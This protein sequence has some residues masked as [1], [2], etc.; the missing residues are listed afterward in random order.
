MVPLQSNKFLRLR[1]FLSLAIL[2]VLL[3]FVNLRTSLEPNMVIVNVQPTKTYLSPEIFINSGNGF[4]RTSYSSGQILPFTSNDFISFRIEF[5]LKPYFTEDDFNFLEQSIEGDVQTS[6]WV[7]FLNPFKVN[8]ENYQSISFTPLDQEGIYE[9]F[10]DDASYS[11]EEVDG[12][13][14]TEN[15]DLQHGQAGRI[16]IARTSLNPA[17]ES[18]NQRIPL[19]IGSVYVL[20][21]TLEPPRISSIEM[22]KRFSRLGL[23]IPMKVWDKEGINECFSNDMQGRDNDADPN[24][25]S[26]KGSFEDTQQEII[27]K[28]NLYM[29]IINLLVVLSVV[30][31]F[32]LLGRLISYFQNRKPE[33]GNEITQFFGNLKGGEKSILQKL[34]IQGLTIKKIVSILLKICFYT[35][36][37]LSFFIA[38]ENRN[39]LIFLFS[40]GCFSIL[41]ENRLSRVRLET[42]KTDNIKRKKRIE[43]LVVLIIV[44]VNG[45]ALFYR[46]GSEGFKEDEFQVIDSAAGYLY[47]GQ[48]SRWD[49][50]EEDI[51]SSYA[52]AWPHTFL[53]AQAFKLLGIS[54]FSGRVVSVLGGVVFIICF[55]FFARFFT[56][57]KIALLTL[58]STSLFP[59]Y[60]GLFRYARMYALLLPMF[61]ILTY[62]I[63]RG[64]TGDWHVKTG[65]KRLDAF[66][67]KKINYDYRF[68]LASI[69]ILY[70][71]Y[72]IHVNS[73]II[74]L[75]AYL[76]VC[77]LAI[78]DKEKKF[79]I[80]AVLGLIV[81]T[82]LISAMI[83][84]ENTEIIR[85]S[86]ESLPKF[87][88]FFSF[89]GRKN[90]V[91]LDYLV[92][93]P[94]G[95][96]GGLILVGLVG[97]IIFKKKKT[98]IV[99]KYLFLMITGVLSAIF[100]I[101]IADRY[102]S[103][104]YISH[105]TPITLLLIISGFYYLGK[106]NLK[107]PFILTLLLCTLV[108]PVFWGKVERLY[109]GV[110]RFGD[111][112]SAYQVIIENYDEESDVI[113]GQY[114][115]AYYLKDLET[116][117]AISMMNNRQYT[118]E[119]F[120][121]DLE[122]YESGWLTW[123]SR[124]A[125]H[126]DNQ[127]INYANENFYQIHGRDIDDFR[128][129]VYY[130]NSATK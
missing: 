28:I 55:Y 105:I 118:Y 61:L 34:G 91:Y 66:V 44:I 107:K 10:I 2:I 83:I 68:L 120:L 5:P 62:C 117:T 70:L 50:I 72:L 7:A 95:K 99:N 92:S 15:L 51:G 73:L 80:F 52:R 93:Y 4:E 25:L 54:E 81:G 90:F 14:S 18:E 32:L 77:V 30:V 84:L 109:G 12:V 64:L 38:H 19:D 129:E 26:F 22:A 123:E 17:G 108:F 65:I 1:L 23:T 39:V 33:R 40:S 110:T 13:L 106:M 47:T 104:Y 42:R 98:E 88:M 114:L 75:A 3:V 121:E 115:R 74:V 87:S 56:N 79:I 41:I 31:F 86:Y 101:Y 97:F 113:F 21:K 111:F 67:S 27:T 102:A 76:F 116:F 35:S 103:Y 8:P 11:L 69:P 124:K 49:W 16:E 85:Y 46:L 94:F 6:T 78:R 130:F 9:L 126:V 96:I 60:L 43:T 127:I 71:T 29:V 53:I 122:E 100:F 24:H 36:L 128:V 37:L 59:A 125:Y 63:Y 20:R 119:L 45:F 82:L 89:F 58:F 48:F 57:R 112:N